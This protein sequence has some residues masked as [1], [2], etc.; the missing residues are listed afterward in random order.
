[1][2]QLQQPGPLSLQGNL[3][4]NWRRWKQQFTIY[5]TA[6]G[7]TSASDEVKSAI[8]LHLVGPNA[9]DIFNTFT[10]TEEGDAK[11]LNKVIEKFETYCTPR[12][13]VTWERH[14]SNTR[15]QKPGET[16]DEYIT[17]LRIK[18][19]SCEFGDLT[20]GLIRD[21]IVCGI[22]SDKTRSRLLKKEN[23]TLTTALDICHAD[24]A[25]LT[26][27]K[28]MSTPKQ[29]TSNDNDDKEV[30]FVKR[31]QRRPPTNPSQTE[32]TK[33]PQCSYCG[34]HHHPQQGCPAYSVNCHKFGRRN[35]FA[36]VCRSKTQA[37]SPHIREIDQEEE[38]SEDDLLIDVVEGQNKTN[39][40][41]TVTINS[42]NTKFKIDTGAQCNVISSATYHQV[43]KQPLRKS[44][45][46]L[47]AFG[48][49]RLNSLS[50][51][52]L[53]CTHK[54]KFWPIEFEVIDN[55]SN[56]LGLETCTEMCLIKCVEALSNDTLK[57]YADTFHGLGCITD[58]THHIELDPNYK[59]VVHP[60]RRVPVTMRSKVKRELERMERLD[61]IERVHGP[62]DWVNSMVTVVKKKRATSNMY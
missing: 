60:P 2:E 47:I 31:T 50:K 49:H 14:V 45:S 32:P 37:K 38:S 53:L 9:L 26:Q 13:N 16:I 61:V 1:M 20:E 3:S 36:K 48:G 5:M 21:R 12:K 24:E 8:F 39:W 43:S 51:T 22:I 35:H 46:R 7:K 30:Q 34:G 33:S 58:V 29:H 44:K 15:S 28:V 4:E 25:A 19:R 52:T 10:F 40:N 57:R 59:P 55:V 6:T 56:I 27:V 23:L 18:S 17:D 54:G 11:K 42:H 62:T 41:V